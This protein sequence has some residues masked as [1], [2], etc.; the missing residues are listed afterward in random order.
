MDQ[1][2]RSLSTSEAMH[3][4]SFALMT[5]G[6]LL[7]ASAVL[8]ARGRALRLLAVA[9]VFVATL[10][11][12]VWRVVGVASAPTLDAATVVAAVFL[13]VE[14][15]KEGNTLLTYFFFAR[16]ADR[17][18]EADAGEARLRALHPGD[19]PCVD[20][21]IP[22]YNEERTILEKTIVG[23]MGIEWPDLRIWV[24]D[25]GKRDWLEQMCREMGVRYLRRSDNRH[26]KAGNL[27]NA[28]RVSRDGAGEYIAMFD[29]DF[30]ARRDFLYRT[31]GFFEDPKVG[32]VQTP[33]HFYNP[34]P[35]QHN[36]LANDSVTD[37][38]R[39][40]FDIVQPCKDAWDLAYCCGTSAVV[41]RSC[42]ERLG[43][44]PHDTVTEDLLL[45]Y[46]LLDA[47]YVTRYLN[48]RLSIGLSPE[49]VKEYLTQRARW[50]TGTLQ[51]LYTRVG[52]F[53]HSRLTLLQ[54]AS[55]LNIMLSWMLAYP[56]MLM[57]LLGPNLYW[58]LGWTMV[59]A[60][61]GEFAA[62]FLPFAVSGY[63]LLRT[64]CGSRSLPVINDCQTI[65]GCFTFTPV[66]VGTL[67]KPFGHKFK[68][69]AKGGDRSQKVVQWGLLAKIAAVWVVTLGGLVVGALRGVSD[70]ADTTAMSLNLVWSSYN[71]VILAVAALVTIEQPRRR[72]EERFRVD[73]P[74][75]LWLGEEVVPCTVFDLSLSGARVSHAGAANVAGPVVLRVRGVGA[76]P[77]AAVIG[78]RPGSTKMRFDD[79]GH[80]QRHALV[81]KLFAGRHANQP[82]ECRSAASMWSIVRRMFFK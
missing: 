69:T 26:A 74:G 1:V 38:Q 4:A 62:V 23:A 47:G 41:R 44:F 16:H 75:E 25:D 68:V 37:Q 59:P 46:N 67:L 15:C 29:A 54:R 65:I 43:G 42:I 66:I 50:C 31:L 71:L 81:R 53:S 70:G 19:L 51:Q 33:Q 35:V 57:V 20:V 22:T 21:F 56:F 27:N 2:S 24:L 52:P 73:E 61:L 60:S 30:V 11:Y 32:V 63:F 64:V 82:E 6:V 5:L 17:S 34:D 39:A 8:P 55:L 79:V 36:L 12:L 9:T 80:G 3:A 77:A 45:T 48:E 28:F 7:L 78:S 72:G 58:Y 49:G 13:A 76:L 10:V 14:V 40:F 18:R